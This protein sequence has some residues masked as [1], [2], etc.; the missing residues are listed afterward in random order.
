[1]DIR[2]GHV[3]QGSQKLEPQK[4]E[5]DPN[6]LFGKDS[7]ELMSHVFTTTQ[8]ERVVVE[9]F[10]LTTTQLVIE[11]VGGKGSGEWFSGYG[12]LTSQRSRVILDI[13]G[14]WRCVVSAIGQD[15]GLGTFFVQVAR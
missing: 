1:M 14:R 13:P 10:N 12:V 15:N 6:I 9:A 7:V 5:A 8:S 2:T 4:I 3:I 11:R